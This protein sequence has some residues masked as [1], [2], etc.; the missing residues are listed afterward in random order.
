[1]MGVAGDAL[2]GGALDTRI[3]DWRCWVDTVRA[4]YAA[5][6]DAWPAFAAELR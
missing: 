4:V 6:D 2:R 5:A 1:M 3:A